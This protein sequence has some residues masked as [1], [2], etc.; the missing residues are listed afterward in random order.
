MK[1]QIWSTPHLGTWLI[2]PH[3]ES[4]IP[5]DLFAFSEKSGRKNKIIDAK[6]DEKSKCWKSRK[7][8]MPNGIDI[9]MKVRPGLGSD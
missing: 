5:I 9:E 1:V 2:Q 6:C 8:K 3:A 7:T 4:S